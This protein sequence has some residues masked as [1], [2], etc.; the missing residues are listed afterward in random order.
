MRLYF[1]LTN[2]RDRI[3]DEEGVEVA[4]VEAA[5]REALERSPRG[6][7]RSSSWKKY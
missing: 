6:P 1:H 4:D 2:G 3:S 7:G 5:R